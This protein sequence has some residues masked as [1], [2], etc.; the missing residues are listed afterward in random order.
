MDQTIVTQV[1]IAVATLLASLAGFLLA[2]INERRRDEPIHKR[3]IELRW[4]DRAAKL[5][6]EKHGLQRE[7]LL[8]MQD[9]LQKAARLDRRESSFRPHA[10][11]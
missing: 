1:V 9:A 10:G 11:A 4:L 2:G 5:G 6:N 7:T 8:A 3:E